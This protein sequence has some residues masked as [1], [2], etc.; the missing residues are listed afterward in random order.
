MWVSERVSECPQALPPLV[1][2]SFDKQVKGHIRE[3]I[4]WEGKPGDKAIK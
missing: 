2:Y 3:I 1:Q 4:A